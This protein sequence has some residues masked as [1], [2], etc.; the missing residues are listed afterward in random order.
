MTLIRSPIPAVVVA[1]LAATAGSSAARAC[2][3]DAGM[4]DLAAAH[5]RSI[6][7]AI[8]VRDAFDRGTVRP[9]PDVPLRDGYARASGLLRGFGR[10]IPA[11]AGVQSGSVTLLLIESGLWA[12]YEVTGHGVEA[13]LHVDGAREHEPV[14]ITS[15]A[16]VSALINGTL[17]LGRAVQL[18]VL[19]AVVAGPSPDEDG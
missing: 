8:A 19:V 13:E 5:P 12:R 9:L 7:V 4:P 3:Y 15:E 6:A 2:G 1:L 10:L 14:I 18:G 11:A 16:A 17:E